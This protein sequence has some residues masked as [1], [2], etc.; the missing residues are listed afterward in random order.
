MIA[1]HEFP[2]VWDGFLETVAENLGSGEVD[3]VDASLR[4]VIYTIERCDDRFHIFLPQLLPYLF[5]AFTFAEATPKIREKSLY[6]YYLSLRTVAWADGL[7]NDLIARCLDE[8]FNMWMALFLQ[9][10]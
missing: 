3:V 10:V 9:I 7:D 4:V 5:S 8:T 6:A 2:N 1:F